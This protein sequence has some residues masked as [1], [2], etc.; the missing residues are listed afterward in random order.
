[1]S[2]ELTLPNLLN[3]LKNSLRYELYEASNQVYEKYLKEEVI[4]TIVEAAHKEYQLAPGDIVYSDLS[5]SYHLFQCFEVR[6]NKSFQTFRVD[7][8]SWNISKKDYFSK[9]DSKTGFDLNHF[10]KTNENKFFLL[11]EK[12]PYQV[13]TYN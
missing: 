13:R 4:K 12:A 2:S 6:F 5:K 11:P 7:T 10:E 9:V 1:M 3:S 8:I